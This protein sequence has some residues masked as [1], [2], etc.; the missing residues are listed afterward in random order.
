MARFRGWALGL[1]ALSALLTVGVYVSYNLI[2]VQTQG[3][4][5]FPALPAI[6]LAVATGWNEVL[7]PSTSRWAAGAL[8]VAAALAGLWGVLQ[9]DISLWSMSILAGGS[10]MALFWSLLLPRWTPRVE[11]R[12]TGVAFALPFI[13]LLALDILALYAFILPQLT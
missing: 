1:L 2:F 10:A 8:L 13:G 7:R 12:L 6:A 9:H 3:R 11:R 5:L 4:Y